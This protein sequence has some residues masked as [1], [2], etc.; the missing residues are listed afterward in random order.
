MGNFCTN[1]GTKLGRYD[2]FCTNCGAKVDKSDMKQINSSLNQH[3]DSLENKNAK[4]E[5]KKVVGGSSASNKTF[6]NALVENGLDIVR[7]GKD[8][9]QQ[10]EKEIDSGQIKS[11]GVEFR[12]NQLIREY[13]IKKEEEKRKL[14]MIDEIFES[15]EI[16]LEITKNNIDQIRVTS[17]KDSLKNRIIDKRENMGE[18]EIKHFIKTELEKV[19]KEKEEEKRKLKMI[20]EIFESAEIRLEITKNNID[21]Q[22]A[23]YIKDNLKNDL[24]NKKENMAEGEIKHL[25]K[26]ELEHAGRER[27]KARIAREKERVRKEIEK[28]KRAYGGYCSHN[29][30]NCYEELLDSHGG[31][32]G[33]Y[34]DD[35]M[36]EYYCRLGHSISWGKFCEDYK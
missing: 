7:D 14:K 23:I 30:S 15:A 28:N 35:G 32:I 2:N 31:V 4:K 8:I 27:E 1:C 6:A 9:R 17:I 24:I 26:T 20:D 18:M 16:R 19:I 22:H 13:A 5:L 10:V 11:G 21:P 3:Y 34:T 29:C 33:E 36:F 25:I 12:V